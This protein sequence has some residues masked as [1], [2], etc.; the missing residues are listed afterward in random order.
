MLF[1]FLS[2]SKVMT[3]VELKEKIIAK[4]SETDD[5]E[6]LEHISDLIDFEHND[7]HEM[8]QGEIEAVE[9]G[10]RQIEN[11]QSVPHEEVKRRMD[12]WLKK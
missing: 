12:E 1:V 7:V 9:D 6:L 10:I 3:V 5:E 11:G 4:I 2:K 8:S